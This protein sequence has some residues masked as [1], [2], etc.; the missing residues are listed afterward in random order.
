M[1]TNLG[2][3]DGSPLSGFVESA[4][5]ARNG[6]PVLVVMGAFEGADALTT[7]NVVI[8]DGA[9]FE[10]MDGGVIKTIFDPS[11]DA[12]TARAWAGGVA[13]CGD[14]NIAGGTPSVATENVALYDRNAGTWSKFL[15]GLTGSV[16][17][18]LELCSGLEVFGG[19][20]YACGK[21]DLA[22]GTAVT[23]VAKWNGT[24]WSNPGGLVGSPAFLKTFDGVL[25]MTGTITTGPGI[26]KLVGGTWTA[27]GS[28][29]KI[30]GLDAAG[31]R[32][33]VAD[34]KLVV[35]GRYDTFNG[36]SAAHIAFWDGSTVTTLGTGITGTRTDCAAVLGRK[37]YVGG[38]FTAAGGVGA[39]NIAAYDL[40]AG[41]WSALGTGLSSGCNDVEAFN[42]ELYATGSFTT[43][44]GVAVGRIAKWNPG[45]ATW[46]KVGTTGLT[47]TGTP[48][49]LGLE[50][51]FA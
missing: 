28:G 24:A 25:Y 48:F 14:F 4:Q 51:V 19:E 34:N 26:V 47:S 12:R 45:T 7:D 32:M 46:S 3:F 38:T 13:V 8:W 6:I 23:N 43:A 5:K 49:G 50:T 27:L 35:T 44:G 2:S 15:G 21:F 40:D 17:T 33:T 16:P 29:L 22:G 18:G 37:L 39:A 11:V 10:D 9:A 31:S 42:G 36:V 1:G 41:T 20:L 30:G